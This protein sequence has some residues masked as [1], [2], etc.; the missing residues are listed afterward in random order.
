MQRVDKIGKQNAPCP[1]QNERGSIMIQVKNG[2]IML[3]KVRELSHKQVQRLESLKTESDRKA[4]LLSC[5]GLQRARH[6]PL[7]KL[8]ATG[9]DVL[10][11]K[12]KASVHAEFRLITRNGGNVDHKPL[13]RGQWIGV[14]VECLIPADGS[15]TE[16]PECDGNGSHG[17]DCDAC[18]GSGNVRVECPDC[19]GKDSEC[20][21]CN[22]SG[23]VEIECG[24][25]EGSGRDSIECERC[26]GSGEVE[27][28]GDSDSLHESIRSALKDAKVYRASVR[29][30][31]S[32]SGD[33]MIG[34]E[35]TILLN[36]DNGWQPLERALDVLK[37]QFNAEVNKTCGLH[38][39]FDFRKAGREAALEAGKRLGMALPALSLIV[40]ESR[41]SNSYCKLSVSKFSGCRYHAV[42]LTAFNK[43]G[44]LEVRLHG[45]T[46]EARKIERWVTLL[47]KI[48][49]TARPAR[50][51]SVVDLQ[52]LMDAYHLDDAMCAYLDER[53][54][55]F[56]AARIASDE[57]ARALAR[58]AVQAMA[59]DLQAGAAPISGALPPEQA[60]IENAF[61]SRVR[62]L[63]TIVNDDSAPL[64][65]A[66]IA[67]GIESMIAR[68]VAILATRGL[69]NS[70]IGAALDISD[71]DAAR[72]LEAVYRATGLAG[73]A[74]LIVWCLPHFGA[75]ATQNQ[76]LNSE[77]A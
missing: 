35:V 68:A 32:L 10:A 3:S 21:T 62:E 43:H 57:R 22:G 70:E 45:G 67:R 71:L 25:C 46:L 12:D 1:A 73:R 47:R 2:K 24:E 29:S 4:Y 31:G 18:N 23:E 17:I 38:V 59:S 14:E 48:M 75:V 65:S 30:D 39:H 55:K 26:G 28:D 74:Q 15:T 54:Q 44:S 36:T 33:G 53:W 6:L 51:S 5:L 50:A 76:N 69:A 77:V 7:N 37:N 13:E 56:N 27:C 16:C 52:G 58:E 60:S 19:H 41:R 66:L 34:V 11:T 49:A 8:K 9:R 64:N 40:P 20:E 63:A 72:I 61:T 42:N